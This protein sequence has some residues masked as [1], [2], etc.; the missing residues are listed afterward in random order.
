[1]PIPADCFEPPRIRVHNG[2]LER[3]PARRR[4]DDGQPACGYRGESDRMRVVWRL[5]AEFEAQWGERPIPLGHARQ[6][7]VLA[8]LLMDARQ[9]V[10][11]GQLIERV[12]GDHAPP[13][14]HSTL[15]G[16]LSRL[17]RI[18]DGRGDTRLERQSGGYVLHTDPADIDLHQFRT[19]AT[20]ARAAGDDAV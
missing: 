18:L 1:M 9:P 13:G 7:C 12:W 17:R 6:R 4:R 3:A 15:Y 19:L 20:Q 5:L 11:V 8:A 14:T 2:P 10:P 16:Y